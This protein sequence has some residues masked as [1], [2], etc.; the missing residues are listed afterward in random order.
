M[1]N[2]KEYKVVWCVEAYS[3]EDYKQFIKKDNPIIG[4]SYKK[5]EPSY[6]RFGFVARVGDLIWLVPRGG[7]PGR[8]GKLVSMCKFHPHH[9][10]QRRMVQW[11]SKELYLNQKPQIP[12]ALYR[13]STTSTIGS[14]ARMWNDSAIDE[15]RLMCGFEPLAGLYSDN[16]LIK[17][18]TKYLERLF[19]SENDVERKFIKPWLEEMK[20]RVELAETKTQ[21]NWDMVA[22]KPGVGTFLV[23][24]KHTDQIKSKKVL[25]LI[26]EADQKGYGAWWI[27][28][29]LI[30]GEKIDLL[31]EN[32][33]NLDVWGSRE[34]Y[35]EFLEEY[36]G[37]SGRFK[38][39]VPLQW[40]LIPPE[41]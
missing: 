33:E 23:Q 25:D 11:F 4:I 38:K 8:A 24:V 1:T 36:E 18:F 2:S 10:R 7:R 17:N 26:N 19:R 32:S 22:K 3:D 15:I 28:L 21:E 27:G 16:D 31:E 12:N 40:A 14:F 13:Y 5:G 41:D 6:R 29:G 35:Y 37:Y 20:F 39:M 9:P 34:I 30:R